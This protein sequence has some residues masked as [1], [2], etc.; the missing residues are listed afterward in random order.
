MLIDFWASW[1]G[2]CRQENPNVVQA[3]KQFK[4]KGKGF[5]IY[6]VSLDQEKGK[7]EKAIAAD[8]FPTAMLLGML[9]SDAMALS[10]PDRPAALQ[11]R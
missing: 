8:G 4:D 10:V 11:D 6:S 3:Y 2:P 1:C 9:E 7:W 5:T